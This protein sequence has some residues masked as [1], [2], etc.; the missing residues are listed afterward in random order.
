M[1]HVRCLSCEFSR[2]RRAC[3]RF[4]VGAG[5]PHTRPNKHPGKRE[6]TQIASP[7]SV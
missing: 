3:E 4:G 5:G 7:V 1:L 6:R 2:E